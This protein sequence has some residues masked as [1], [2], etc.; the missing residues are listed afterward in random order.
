MAFSHGRLT[1]FKVG[2]ADI[3]PYCKTSEWTSG[4]DVHDV[5]GYGAAGHGYQGGLHDDKVT[6]SGTYDTT[7]AGPRKII[8]PLVMATTTVTRQP[9]GAGSGK[10]QDL[11]TVV[12]KSYVETNPVADMVQWAAE[13]TISGVTNSAAQP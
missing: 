9:E 13:F 8:E 12:V 10:P 5:T 2:A 1:V 3:S 6:V 7:V 4:G 11:A